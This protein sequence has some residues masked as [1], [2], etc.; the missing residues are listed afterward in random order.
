MGAPSV[1]VQHEVATDRLFEA[2]VSYKQPSQLQDLIRACICQTKA[3]HHSFKLL[4]FRG[5]RNT[6]WGNV[7]VGRAH[8]H[9]RARFLPGNGR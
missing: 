6:R 9:W 4:Y 8:S 1:S 5:K 7:F 3:R 2:R